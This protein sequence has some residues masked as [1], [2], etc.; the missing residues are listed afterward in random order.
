MS[1]ARRCAIALA[2]AVWIASAAS[3]G[4][5]GDFSCVISVTDVD[6][7]AYD[8]FAAAPVQSTGTI[9]Y[10]CGNRVKDVTITISRGQS[11]TYTPRVMFRG[12]DSL[13]YN[14]YMDAA[15]TAV[16]GDGTSGTGVYSV[17]NARNNREVIVTIYGNIPPLQD[18]TAGTY[19]D[20][21]TATINF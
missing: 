20:D 7:G 2:A 8:V 11:A 17:D 15:R 12:G 4:A 19:T 5:Q 1:A 21:V 6:F 13:F 3:T 10:R 9:A 14:L 18:V 16:W